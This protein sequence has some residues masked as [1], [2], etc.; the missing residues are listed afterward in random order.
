MIVHSR[1]ESVHLR[2]N[3]LGIRASEISSCTCR[4]ATKAP[5]SAIPRRNL[6][7]RLRKGRRGVGATS[8]RRAPMDTSYRRRARSRVRP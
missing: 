6:P 3:L 2:G 5:T 4:T 7:P 8:H 1:I